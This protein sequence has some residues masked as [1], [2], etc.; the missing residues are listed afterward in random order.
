MLNMLRTAKQAQ[1]HSVAWDDFVALAALT[2]TTSSK[3]EALEKALQVGASRRVVDGL[4]ATVAGATTQSGTGLSNFGSLLGA[5]MASVRAVS[6]FDQVA[7]SA[8]RLPQFVGR[9]IV[10]SVVGTSSVNEGAGKPL[11]SLTLAATDIT[12]KKIV[13][14]IVMSKELIDGLGTE[15]MDS[16]GNEL[17]KSV[18]FGSDTEFLAALTGNANEAV[19]GSATFAGILDDMSELA[20]SVQTGAGSRL[21]YIVTSEIA[22]ALAAGAAANGLVGMGILGGELMGVPVLVSDAQ[23]NDRITLVDASGLAVFLGEISLKSSEEATVQM[24]SAPS[25]D[26]TTGTGSTLVSMWQTNSFALMAEREMA[27]K[28]IR[29]SSYAHMDSVQA[30]AFESPAVG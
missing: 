12:P 20:R 25:Q 14:Q 16:L 15:A 4:K 2:M 21:F 27:V 1:D 11:R 9:V 6:A 5:F 26:S 29:P 8:M 30:S 10:S 18:A 13:S 28:P 23:A 24:D 3:A 7:A 22:K 17:R 19:G